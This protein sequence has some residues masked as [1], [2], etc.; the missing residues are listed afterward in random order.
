MAKTPISVGRVFCRVLVT[1]S[2]THVSGLPL[3]WAQGP[4]LGAQRAEERLPVSRRAGSS[5]ELRRGFN[6][7]DELPPDEEIA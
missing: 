1:E 2:V 4:D 6:G 5:D 7:G 3:D